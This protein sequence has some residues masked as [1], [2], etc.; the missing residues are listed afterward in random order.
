MRKTGM[1][2]ALVIALHFYCP[3]SASVEVTSIDGTFEKGTSAPV[4]W[5]PM[6]GSE[7]LWTEGEAHNGTRALAAKSKKAAT[8]WASDKISISPDTRYIVDG[9]IKP[10]SGAGWLEVRLF[11]SKDST[12]GSWKSP[13]VTRTGRWTY[14][15]VETPLYFKSQKDEEVRTAEIA[16]CVQGGQVALD[17]VGI[18]PAVFMEIINGDFENPVDKKGR[19]PFWSEEE[20]DSLLPGKRGGYLTQREE[21]AFDGKSSVALTTADDWFAVSTIHYPISPWSDRVELSAVAYCEPNAQAQAVAVWTD[22]AQRVIGVNPSEPMGADGWQILST[23]PVK[24][25]EGTYAL[26]PALAV[27]KT[28]GAA[29]QQATAWFDNVMF[30]IQDAPFVRVVVN[31]VGYEINGPKSAVVMTNFFP[32]ETPNGKVEIVTNDDKSVWQSDLTCSGRMVGQEKTDWGWYFWRADFSSLNREGEYRVRADL[33][34]E[35]GVSYPFVIGKDLLFRETAAINVD[36]FF[37]QRCGFDVPGWF[38]ACHLDDAKLK[39]GTHRDLTGGW[40]SAGDYNKLTWE[41]GD[42]G[43]MYALINAAEA[44][45]AYFAQYDRDKD[46]LIDVFDEAWWGAKFLAKLQIEDTG[47]LLNHIEQG[48]NRKT[49]MNWCPPNKTTDNIIGTEDDP[50][51]IEGNGNSPLAIGGWAR[52]ARIL[53][54]REIKTDYLDR[55]VRLWEHATQKGTTHSDPLLLI[56]TVD[57]YKVTGEERFLTFCQETVKELLA[58]GNPEGQLTGGYANSGDIPAAALAHFA[59][60]FPEDSL[61]QQVKTRLEK[62]VPYFVAEAD[63]PLQIMIQKTGPDGYFFEPTSSLGCNYQFGSRAWSALMI[64]RVTKDRSVLEYAMNQLDFVLGKN[65]YDICMMEGKGTCNLPRYHHRYITIPGH[66]RGAVPGAIP[67]GFVRDLAGNDRPGMDLST[68]GRLYPSYRTNEPWM[69]HNVF[70]T[71]AVTALHE[72]QQ[73]SPQEE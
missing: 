19:I 21:Q 50:I 73:I 14:V 13:H 49:W 11:D 72:A 20:D 33:G 39:D 37:V 66:E 4:G 31:Q 62:H 57:L 22:S 48:P 58:S 38:P 30:Q 67:N 44:A 40:H 9:W 52:L 51:V 60:S 54:S 35:K 69:V 59:L 64:Y 5:S 23:G 26:R 34:G 42:G 17:D 6:S 29:I 61:S 10:S 65:P 24:P 36:F 55:A 46:G 68:G 2:S 7:T 45:P 27:R 70:Y 47:G 63:N 53:E 25:P 8:A 71:L 3:T 56:S 12:I 16:F 41:Y 43:V 28:A 18:H 15:A 32:G 1:L